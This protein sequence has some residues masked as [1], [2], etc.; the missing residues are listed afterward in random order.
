[1]EC[2]NLYPRRLGGQLANGCE[3]NW[4]FKRAGWARRANLRAARAKRPFEVGVKLNWG[5]RSRRTPARVCRPLSPRRRSQAG[6]STSISRSVE[7]GDCSAL[8]F[9]Q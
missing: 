5:G 3:A 8:R 1:M 4:T 9:S 2:L 6:S 7:V